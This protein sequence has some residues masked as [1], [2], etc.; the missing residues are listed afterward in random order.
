MKCVI[1]RHGTTLPGLTTVTL[2][3]D[4]TTLVVKHVPARLCANCG[5]AYFDAEV[6]D[7]LLDM[8]TAAVSAQVQVE[9]RH[10]PIAKA[11]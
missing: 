4:A 9:V 10:Y 7:A 6:T 3:R 5:E 2:E 1:C 11:S 8:M